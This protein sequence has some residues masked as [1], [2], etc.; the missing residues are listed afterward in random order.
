MTKRKKADIQKE[1]KRDILKDHRGIIFAS[2]YTIIKKQNGR[3]LFIG[4]KSMPYHRV[5]KSYFCHTFHLRPKNVSLVSVC[6]HFLKL[7]DTQTHKWTQSLTIFCQNTY[8]CLKMIFRPCYFIFF[9]H[10][11]SVVG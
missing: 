6:V 5:K 3:Y 7:L 10:F 8:F 11:A 9:P 2:L 4:A 1:K